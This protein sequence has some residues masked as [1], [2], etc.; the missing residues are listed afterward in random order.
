MLGDVALKRMLVEELDLGQRLWQ[1]PLGFQ[2]QETRQRRCIDV[3]IDQQRRGAGVGR[4]RM[5]QVAGN[6]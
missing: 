2:V 1:A 6:E 5:R 3:E 4:E